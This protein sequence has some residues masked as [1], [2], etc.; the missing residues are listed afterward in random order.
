[1]FINLIDRVL[2]R[3]GLKGFITGEIS[4]LIDLVNFEVLLHTLKLIST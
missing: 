4:H 2:G 1:M 3:Q